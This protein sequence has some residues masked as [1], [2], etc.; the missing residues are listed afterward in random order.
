M[1]WINRL[2]LFGGL[3]GVVLLVAVLTLIFNQRQT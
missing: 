3:L 1:T 2:R